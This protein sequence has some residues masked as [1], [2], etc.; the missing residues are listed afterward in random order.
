MKVLQ[1][2]KHFN[3]LTFYQ[4][5]LG[6]L[7]FMLDSAWCITKGPSLD[8]W[9]GGVF[10]WSFLFI[11]QGR[12]KALFPSPQDRLEIFLSMYLFQPPLR[13]KYL[14]PPCLVA[15]YLFHPFF[16]QNYLFKKQIQATSSILMWYNTWIVYY[17]LVQ[18]VR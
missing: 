13:I 15:I 11:S 9:G 5:W 12:L 7:A 1:M 3:N 17:R 6:N 14:F 4:N 18:V 2:G 16:P 10:A 8:I